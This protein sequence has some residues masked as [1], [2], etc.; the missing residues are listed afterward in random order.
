M[1]WVMTIKGIT[2][3][4]DHPNPGYSPIIDYHDPMLW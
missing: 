1:R 3:N 2:Y 4:L